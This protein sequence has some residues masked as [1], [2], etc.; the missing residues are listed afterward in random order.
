VVE[1]VAVN[2]ALRQRHRIVI[3]ILGGGALAVLVA[4]HLVRAGAP[5]PP[6]TPPHRDRSAAT[7]R[8]AWS[9]RSKDLVAVISPV[10]DP[11]GRITGVE[12][13]ERGTTRPADLLLYWIDRSPP[14]EGL[15][16]DAV[17]LG[18]LD[19]SL[20]ARFVLPAAADQPGALLVYSEAERRVVAGADLGRPERAPQ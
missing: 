5:Q 15:P 18:S 6:G 20:P 17:L 9:L 19:G 7:D 14:S 11:D 4:A 1:G 12:I 3:P 16:P 13:T 2:R 8:F 10:T